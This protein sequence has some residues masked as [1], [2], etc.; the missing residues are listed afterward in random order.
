MPVGPWWSRER[1]NC[2]PSI[3]PRESLFASVVVPCPKSFVISGPTPE[4]DERR[5]IARDSLV[6]SA[7]VVVAVS[8]SS[9]FFAHG[10]GEFIYIT[11][12]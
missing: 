2:H 3:P 9:A 1:I 4:E 8:S 6:L 11:G 12:A 7:T 10:G 5:K